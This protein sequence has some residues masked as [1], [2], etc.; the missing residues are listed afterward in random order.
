MSKQYELRPLSWAVAPVDEPIFSEMVTTISIGDEAAGEFVIVEQNARED[1]GKIAIDPVEW[2]S[3]RDAIE[4]AI[5]QCRK[6]Q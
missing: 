3:I 1:M 4:Q 6:T 2:P 5:S